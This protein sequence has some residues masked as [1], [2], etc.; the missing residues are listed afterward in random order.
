MNTSFKQN[1]PKETSIVFIGSGPVAAKSLELLSKN[2]LI[3]AVISKPKPKHHK[4]SSPVLETAQQMKL[5]VHTVSSKAEISELIAAK[6]FESKLAILIDF[7]ILVGLDAINYFQFGIVN[8][9]FSL[10]P[11][12]RGA[13]PITF[14]LLSGQSKTGVSLM[15][16]AEGL[17]T[18]KI[19]A[20]KTLNISE[21]ADSW[22][23]TNEL[24]ILSDSM[25]KENIPKYISGNLKPRNQPHPE[26]ATYSKKLTKTDGVIDWNKAAVVIDREIRAYCEWPKST[27]T[28]AN[29]D[30][31]VTEAHAFD[32]SGLPG[33]FE[34]QDKSLIVFTGEK[35]LRILKLK[36]AGKKEMTIEAFLAGYKNNI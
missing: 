17:D 13:D 27:T 34:V 19:I 7:G 5:P 36:P 23:L 6:P 12:W 30:V 25:L 3:E 14:T 21:K 10:L 15:L 29:K 8:S 11:E 1:N 35:A 18:G 9:H 26:R 4:G 32:A 16:V 22:S 20:Q 28:I 2:F 24:I 31:I 33:V